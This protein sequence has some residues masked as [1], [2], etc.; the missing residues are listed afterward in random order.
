VRP[1]PQRFSQVASPKQTT[2]RPEP[3]QPG[4]YQR[5]IRSLGAGCKGK[6]TAPTKR[7]ASLGSQRSRAEMGNPVEDERDSGLKANTIPL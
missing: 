7:P 3:N 1:L 5:K 4:E 6:Q 2:H